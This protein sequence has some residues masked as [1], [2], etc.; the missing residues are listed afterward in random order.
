MSRRQRR[1]GL[2]VL[3]ILAT[4]LR[5]WD[6]GGCSLQVDEAM[7]WLYA[8]LWRT[9]PSFDVHPPLFF[10]TLQGWQALGDTTLLRDVLGLGGGEGWL[11]TL[12]VAASLATLALW[13][14]LAPRLRLTPTQSLLTGLML[15]VSFADLQQARELR[16]YAWLELWAV[17]HL[18]AVLER[19][20]LLAGL[21]L[22]AALFTH[23]FGLFL[24][25]L[26]WLALALQRREPAMR[27]DPSLSER[28]PVAAGWFTSGR[29]WWLS[30]AG[31][32][33][34]WLAWAVPF[35]RGHADHDLGLRA[36]PSLWVAVEAVGRLVAGRIAPFGDPLS[37]ALGVVAL[38]SIAARRPSLPALVYAWALLPWLGLFLLARF[39]PLQL[40]E[41]KYLVW[42]LPAWVALLVPRGAAA[43]RALGVVWCLVNLAGAL[44]WLAHPHGWAADWRGVAAQLRFHPQ[45]E[46]VVVH[47]SMMSAPLIYYGL[48][49]RLHP[50]DEPQRVPAGEDMWWVTTPNHPY[51]ARQRLLDGVAR[52]WTEAEHTEFP[53]QL[54]SGTITLSRWLWGRHVEPPLR[55]P[56]PEKT[57]IR[58]PAHR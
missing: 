57:T 42:T 52:F 39:T 31:I 47:P 33:A 14:R 18:L 38:I 56:P 3:L 24:L 44:P 6:L 58:R 41:F 5:F 15:L 12:P 9:Q 4:L 37:C 1:Y 40:Y 35:Y 20:P 46:A 30:Q 8:A 26:G 51:V 55:T 25:P 53:C 50:A 22:T 23:L 27:V 16:H 48:F 54:P 49:P 32:L 28:L 43:C 2:A 19:R 21:T 13:V 34:L 11:R 17:L 7:S 36:V 10:A 45:P 29:V